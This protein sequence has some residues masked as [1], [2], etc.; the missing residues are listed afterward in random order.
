[1]RKSVGEFVFF[2]MMQIG[3]IAKETSGLLN[4]LVDGKRVSGV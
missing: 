1:M 3:R 4:G 2:A